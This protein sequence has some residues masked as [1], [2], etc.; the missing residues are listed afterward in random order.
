[1]LDFRNKM[2]SLRHKHLLTLKTLTTSCL[3]HFSICS[4]FIHQCLFFSVLY[5]SILHVVFSESSS[6]LIPSNHLHCTCP[7]YTYLRCIICI[8]RDDANDA[9]VLSAKAESAAEEILSNFSKLCQVY[10]RSLIMSLLLIILILCINI[11]IAIITLKT[12]RITCSVDICGHC[13][14]V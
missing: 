9:E 3:L 4:K 6:S 8:I 10:C 1:M 7:D 11:L 12:S 13:N 14:R 5:L 2:W